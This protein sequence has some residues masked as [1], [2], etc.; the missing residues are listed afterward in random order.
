MTYRQIHVW[1]RVMLIEGIIF[2]S[3]SSRIEGIVQRNRMEPG[4]KSP[5]VKVQLF[6]LI[7]YANAWE[8]ILFT[9]NIRPSQPLA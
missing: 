3:R 8:T 9:L 7:A 1:V 4:E 2:M 5:P 6:R